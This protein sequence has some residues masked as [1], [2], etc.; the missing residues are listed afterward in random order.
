LAPLFEAVRTALAES[1]DHRARM[2]VL[3]GDYLESRRIAYSLK[4]WSRSEDDLQGPLD[5]E[6]LENISRAVVQRLGELGAL[7]QSAE[8]R[9]NI[10]RERYNDAVEQFQAAESSR[11]RTLATSEMQEIDAIWRRESEP[12]SEALRLYNHYAASIH[13]VAGLAS[14]LIP[15]RLAEPLSPRTTRKLLSLIA[16]PLQ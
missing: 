12:V 7:L 11:A 10:L 2:A 4:Q 9:L 16:Q 3:L 1:E 15:V 5:G 13:R 8:G 6:L 14:G